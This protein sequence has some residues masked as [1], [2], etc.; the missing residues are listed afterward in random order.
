MEIFISHCDTFF[1]EFAFSPKLLLSPHKSE[2]EALLHHHVETPYQVSHGLLAAPATPAGLGVSTASS[3]NSLNSI[4]DRETSPAIALN[5]I[6]QSPDG[7]SLSS[8]APDHRRNG[9]GGGGGGGVVE[10]GGGLGVINHHTIH[11]PKATDGLLQKL[12]TPTPRKSFK[13]RP[14]PSPAAALADHPRPGSSTLPRPRSETPPDLAPPSR[15]SPVPPE[16]VRP[17]PA[18]PPPPNIHQRPLSGPPSHPPPPVIRPTPAPRDSVRPVSGGLP[19]AGPTPGRPPPSGGTIA[20]KMLS[21]GGGPSLAQSGCP[22]QQQSSSDEPQP[23]LIDAPRTELPVSRTISFS[24]ESSPAVGDGDVVAASAAAGGGDGSASLHMEE[25]DASAISLDIVDT[26]PPSKLA[27]LPPASQLPTLPSEP[28][29]LHPTTSQP[30][31][32][33]SSAPSTSFSV[34]S[35]KP[36][37]P[38]ISRNKPS[39]SDDRENTPASNNNNNSSDNQHSSFNETSSRPPRP[40]SKPRLPHVNST[41]ATPSASAASATTNGG[42]RP[43]PRP[44]GGPPP[45]PGGLPPQPAGPPPHPAGPP[46]HPPS[47]R[48]PEGDDVFTHL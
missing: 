44:T 7:S 38:P 8:F 5:Q 13:Q 35:V 16:I 3:T 4:G 25:V 32:I 9:S 45:H 26:S 39:L 14:A 6:S 22:L 40:Q 17:A 1:P 23:P 43:P 21:S 34:K 10:F 31:C 42:G 24:R 2:N 41:P 12:T 19:T 11:P 18:P 30:A 15:P 46:P 48:L 37:K 27:T 33:P 20:A 36:E 47:N 29:S 28:A